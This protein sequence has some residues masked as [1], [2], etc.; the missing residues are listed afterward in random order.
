M[1]VILNVTLETFTLNNSTES[2]RISFSVFAGFLS[3]AKYLII[4]SPYSN[5]APLEM[6]T[7]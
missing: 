6:P 7:L 5:R 1:P 4:A 3:T 2:L